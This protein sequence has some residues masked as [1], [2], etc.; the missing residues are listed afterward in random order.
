MAKPANHDP[1][2]TIVCDPDPDSV[3]PVSEPEPATVSEPSPFVV[4]S[5]GVREV[6][7]DSLED[8]WLQNKK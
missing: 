1:S 4:V 6:G 7:D 2:P 5:V 3:Y 8:F